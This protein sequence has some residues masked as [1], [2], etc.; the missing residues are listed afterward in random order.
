MTKK[1]K[2]GI[3]MAITNTTEAERIDAQETLEKLLALPTAQRYI[4]VG[5]I[6]GMALAQSSKDNKPD[7]ESA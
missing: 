4:A 6:E 5:V 2:G 3:S 7:G 1:V